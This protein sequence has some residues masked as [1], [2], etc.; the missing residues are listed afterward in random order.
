MR[1]LRPV[2]LLAV[3]ACLLL[4]SS[5]GRAELDFG[6]GPQRRVLGGHQFQ[7]VERHHD[8][9]VTTHLRTSTG[10]GVAS[11]FRTPFISTSG[12][13][14]GVLTGDLGFFTLNMEYQKNLFGRAAVRLLISGTARSGTDEQTLLAEGLS[15]VYGLVLQGKYL[16]YQSEQSS[17]SVIATLTRKNVFGIDPFGFAQHIIDNGGLKKDNSL[18]KESDFNRFSMGTAGAHA[19]Q[20]WLGSTAFVDLG[21]A[22][23]EEDDA[24]LEGMIRVGVAGGFDLLPLKKIP[25]GLTLGYDY[26]SFPEGGAAVAKGIHAATFGVNYTGRPDLHVGLETIVSTLRQANNDSTL[27]ATTFLLALLYYF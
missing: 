8:P 23:P 4:A 21:L 1:V 3:S 20:T 16:A 26:D 12:D 14:L 25:L 11:G 7:P 5:P 18:V 27:A 17:I 6:D 10:V 19:F 24:D 2:G 13:T 9:F 22:Q 15:S